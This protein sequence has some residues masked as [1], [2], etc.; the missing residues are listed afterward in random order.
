MSSKA[1]GNK[2]RAL[3][4]ALVKDAAKIDSFYGHG[5]NE[6]AAVQEG[7]QHWINKKDPTWN[8]LLAP[9]K[10]A[11]IAVQ[12]SNKLKEVLRSKTGDPLQEW[13]FIGSLQVCS[14]LKMCMCLCTC[15]HVCACM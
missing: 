9:M 1:T 5:R 2:G 4:E 6:E 15:V 12:H 3:L 14:Y 7:L 10:N 11:E 8:D 13:L